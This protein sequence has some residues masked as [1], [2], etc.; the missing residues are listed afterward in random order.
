MK[1]V[2]VAGI[3]NI[4]L[5]DDAFGVEVAQRLLAQGTASLPAGVCVADFG[6][7]SY[8]LAYALTDGCDAAVLVDAVA[9]GEAPGTVFLIEPNL[10]ALPADTGPVNS[11]GMNA[12]RALQLAKTVG[13]LPPK[14]LLVGCEPAVLETDELGLSPAVAAAVPGAVRMVEELARSL[15]QTDPPSSLVSTKENPDASSGPGA[16]VSPPPASKFH[17]A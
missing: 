17:P 2:L 13:A 9:R 11:H 3:G 10:G 5:G 1:R 4:F 14:I 6:I 7:R 15:C 8:D 12:A 16:A